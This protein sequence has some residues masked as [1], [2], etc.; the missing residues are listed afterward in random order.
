MTIKAGRV[1]QGNCSMPS[2]QRFRLLPD[3]YR[4]NAMRAEEREGP[5]GRARTVSDYIAGNHRSAR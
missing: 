2:P 3:E 5:A 1:V 4:D